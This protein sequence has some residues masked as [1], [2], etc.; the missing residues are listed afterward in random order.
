MDPVGYLDSDAS[1]DPQRIKKTV[2]NILDW[3]FFPTEPGGVLDP[4]N[5][6]F[7]EHDRYDE[8]RPIT[9]WSGLAKS[10]TPVVVLSS[11][12]PGVDTLVAEAVLEYQTKH[13]DRSVIVRG[14]LP[15]PIDEYPRS[16]TFRP[17]GQEAFWAA[18]LSR[19]HG[20][21][22]RLREQEGWNEKRDLFSIALD[23]D[24]PTLEESDLTALDP[25][26]GK[27]RSHLHYRAAGEYVA[28]YSD[29]LIAIYDHPY[30]GPGNP[31]DLFACGSATIVEAKRQG[32]AWELLSETNN[33]TWADNGPVLR[34]AI[35]RQKRSSPPKKESPPPAKYLD[36]L[37][38]HDV[39][40]TLKRPLKPPESSSPTDAPV[41]ADYE[42]MVQ[43]ERI[44][45]LHLRTCLRSLMKF[46]VWTSL[47]SGSCRSNRFPSPEV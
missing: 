20:L 41:V 36:F 5:G 35:E 15:F 23:N 31:A 47:L 45:I 10:N 28:S 2:K 22:K 44:R 9:C 4:T 14:V 25:D 7:V 3:I 26:F 32:L 12:A 42:T 37:H 6:G 11:L 40:P 18:K 30:D 33:F 1:I 24:F 43:T 17:K 8:D 46:L 19:F 38:P 16:S 27:P 13:S 21:L 39:L 29:L 34:V